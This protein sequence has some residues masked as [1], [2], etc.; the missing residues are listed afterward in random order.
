MDFMERI[1][2]QYS[3]LTRSQ[4]RLADFITSSYLDAAFLSSTELATHLDLDP[5]TVSRFA[6]R[7]GYEGYPELMDNVQDLVKREL[8]DIW[9][10]PGKEPTIADLFRQGMDNGRRNLEEIIICNP[11]QTIEQMVSIL[12]DAGRIFILTP[13][14][15]AY[16]QGCLLEY[17][18]RAADFPVQGVCGDLLSMS[19]C[20]RDARE[21]DVFV[22]VGYTRYAAD[23]GTALRQ[24]S[25]RG[26][27]TIGLVGTVT[28]PIA[29]AC[30]VTLLCP[31][32]SAVAVPSFLAMEGAIAAWVEVLMRRRGAQVAERVQRLWEDYQA[33]TEGPQ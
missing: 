10:P 15:V 5:G 9:Q 1:A 23:V 18:L 28:C 16:H 14:A 31:T 29:E 22:A 24:A 27:R 30:E 17:W 21:G 12:E 2:R 33:L 6:Q 19:L 13:N 32:R 4:Q 25:A 26:A 11:P 8:R 7:L 3:G 20:L